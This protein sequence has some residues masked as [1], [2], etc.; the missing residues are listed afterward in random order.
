M[1]TEPQ[2]TERDTSPFVGAI[3]TFFARLRRLIG[4]LIKFAQRDQLEELGDQ[5]RRLGSATVESVAF[6]SGELRSVEE[7]LSRIEEELAS[8]RR[9]L[10][11]REQDEPGEADARPD[12]IASGP[13]AAG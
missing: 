4:N 8:L 6:V 1:A 5:T 13:T 2:E 3:S 11:E 10:E 9:L 12:R 7:R